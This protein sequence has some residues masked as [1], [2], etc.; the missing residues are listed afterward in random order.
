MVE[1]VLGIIAEYNPFHNGHLYH[2]QESKKITGCKFTVAI[3]SGHFT[4]RGDTSIVDKWTKAKMALN[5]GIDLVIE[6]PLLYS[7]S[8][9]ENFAEGA[10]KILNSLGIVDYIS[11]GAETSN[12]NLLQEIS[13]VLSKEPLDYK[14]L[15]KA[16]LKTGSSYPKARENALRAYFNKSDDISNIINSSNNILGIEYLKALKKLKSTISPICIQRYKTNYN[17][18]EHYDNIAS[19]TSIR[20]LIK[21]RNYADLKNLVPVNS[22]NILMENIKNGNYVCSLHE[23]EKE[24]FYNLRKMSINEISNLQ[25]VSEGLEFVIKSASNSCNDINTFLKLVKSKRY[26]TTRIQRILLYSLLNITKSDI[27]I[28][29]KYE[30]YIR[31]L[32]FNDN[33]KKLISKISKTNPNIKLVTSVKKFININNDDNISLM[34]NKDIFASNVYTLA[35]KTHSLANLDFTKT[36]EDFKIL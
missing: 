31:I 23:F 1:N 20:H 28:S 7:V 32:G 2:L 29:K 16:E 13:N 35:F 17:E 21:C 11:F 6:L 26:T 12:I 24:I 15:L 3:I 5:N 25:D 27:D 10:I 18:V 30:P 34:L 22:Y 19:A 14:N 33:G 9:A 4:Q 36:L 8:S